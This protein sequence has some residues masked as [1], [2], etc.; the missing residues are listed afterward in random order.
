MP[1]EPRFSNAL[2]RRLALVVLAVALVLGLVASNAAAFTLQF[3]GLSPSATKPA[4][5]GAANA[6]GASPAPEE[7]I[8]PDSPRA[9][10][11]DF[12]R[13][14]RAGDYPKAARYLD[15]SEVDQSD[16]PLLA[17]HLREV[18]DRHL[19]IDVDRLS[20][21]P[22]GN[23]DDGLAPDREELG[24][25]PG[26]AGKP[27][28]VVIVRRVDRVGARW[29]FS[30]STVAQIDAWYEHLE[31]RW[32]IEHLPKWALLFGPHELR[33]WQ[34]LALGP[35]LIASWLVGFA[36]TR[37]SRFVIRRVMH[38]HSAETARKLRGPA[39]LAWMIAISYA[40]LPW[41][42]LYEPADAYVRRGLS[43]ALLVALFW[44]L[45]KAVELSQHTW[46]TSHWA[47]NSLTAASLL[48]LAARMGKFAVAAFAF[49][50]VLA[51]LGYP[52]TSIITGLGIG[53]VALALA[54]QK[55]V[56]NLFGA[57]S[58]AV[59]QPFREGD[60][61]QVDSISGTVESIGLRSTRIRTADQTLISIP[62]GKLAEMRVETISARRQIRFYC[63]LGLAYS[64]SQHMTR[65]LSGIESAVRAA[66][67]TVKEGLSVRFIGLTDSAMNVEVAVMIA[68]SDFSKFSEIRQSLL[69]QMVEAVER[70][71]GALARPV[72]RVE[73][74][75][76]TSS[77]LDE[78][79]ANAGQLA[80][81]TRKLEG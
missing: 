62:N 13:L 42:G 44:A 23:G 65:L 50:A 34:W 63:V 49:V 68:T 24:N 56:E 40:A 18:L 4:S 66:P 69:L 1:R 61:I 39:T 48:M 12:N 2:L 72:R 10:L 52:V 28:P 20:P 54:A 45:W 76:H 64:T 16:G 21:E 19:W 30:A 70:A 53:G 27:E 32:L 73:L 25:V 47:K 6:G 43:A 77:A 38:E 74:V 14:T 79:T 29:V 8:A 78:G 9:S 55:T 81:K 31:N 41:L 36:I 3:P 80:S 17:K 59:D 60:V 22:H 11:T 51:E 15:L 71:G 37:A 5:A 75:D 7:K 33:W 26:A 57:F 67:E 46:S 58:L 35:L